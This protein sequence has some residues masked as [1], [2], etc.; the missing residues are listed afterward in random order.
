M[1]LTLSDLRDQVRLLGDYE[2]ST[3][4]TNQ[5]LDDSINKGIRSLYRFKS[6]A[7]EG[8]YTTT[9]TLTTSTGEQDLEVPEDFY[10]LRALDRDLGSDRVAALSRVTL[11]DARR[12][13]GQGI[14]RV[15]T[16]HGPSVDADSIGTIRL[17]P[18]PDGAYDL[19]ITYD[20]QAPELVLDDDDFDFQ[21]DEDEYVI[22][23]ALLRCDQREERPLND[24]KATIAELEQKIRASAPK[25]DS[26]EPEY[27]IPRNSGGDFYEEEW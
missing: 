3:V 15:Y 24:R 11:T 20:P 9:A 13:Q 1:R 2:E 25:R 10:R 14:P 16:L 21:D 27:L 23:Y 18:V 17:F 26:A 6:E 12:Y 7:Y 5:F 19:R 22:E 8:Y 4:F